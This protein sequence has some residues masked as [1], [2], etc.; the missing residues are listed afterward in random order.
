MDAMSPLVRGVRDKPGIAQQM[1]GILQDEIARGALANIASAADVWSAHR[2]DHVVPELTRRL[3]TEV[4]DLLSPLL[5]L[6]APVLQPGADRRIPRTVHAEPPP[7]DDPLGEPMT[8]L[9][10]QSA[11]R[12]GDMIEIRTAMQNDGPTPVDVGFRWSDLV[13]EWDVR[14]RAAHLR[15]PGRLTLPPGAVVDLV[16]HLAVPPDARPGLYHS[17][18]ETTDRGRPRA[19]LIFPVRSQDHRQARMPGDV[20]RGRE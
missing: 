9:H 18:L 20:A 6:I 13:A 8:V 15:L 10:A 14:I 4:S 5:D 16:I 2:A 7:D 1:T 19:L 17:L 3:A 12:P 11:G